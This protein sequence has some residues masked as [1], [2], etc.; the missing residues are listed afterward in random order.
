MDG[1]AAVSQ[2]IAYIEHNLS[3]KLDLQAVAEAVHYSKYHLHRTF[4]RVVGMTVHDY[5]LRRKLTEAAKLL[6]FSNL[7][8]L[9]IALFAG[10]QAPG[11]VIRGELTRKRQFRIRNGQL[12]FALR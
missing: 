6:A 3:Q 12:E 9:H 8:I 2:A 11:S 4:T 7:P 10:Y 1:S 5:G